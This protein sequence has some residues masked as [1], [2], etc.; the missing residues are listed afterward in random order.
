MIITRKNISTFYLYL[1]FS[2]FYNVIWKLMHNSLI[3]Q[4]IYIYMVSMQF[5]R[6]C[7]LFVSGWDSV[8]VIVRVSFHFDFMRSQHVRNS[9]WPISITSC[10]ITIIWLL[11]TVANVFCLPRLNVVD[12]AVA[13]KYFIN[14]A[15]F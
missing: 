6:S 7:C 8:T 9:V 2:K 1:Y 15:I 3:N 10:Q 14:L 5:N 11:T 12:I 13:I 4:Y